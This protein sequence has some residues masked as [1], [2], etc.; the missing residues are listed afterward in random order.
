MID[1]KLRTKIATRLLCILPVMI[2]TSPLMFLWYGIVNTTPPWI[3][4][5][6]NWA[7]DGP[8]TA[9][10]KIHGKSGLITN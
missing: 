3:D 2:G 1:R 9:Y 6:M 5:L 10:E 8:M 7:I 4:W